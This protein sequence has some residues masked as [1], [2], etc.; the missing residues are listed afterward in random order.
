VVYF[1]KGT[2]GEIYYLHAFKK[3]TQK[4]AEKHQTLQKKAKEYF[5]K[6]HKA[7]NIKI[8][9]FQDD[10]AFGNYRSEIAM[11]IID[12]INQ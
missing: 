7:K 9:V 6:K 12:W 1:F 10:H 5:K 3:K 11:T 4:T 8:V 2:K